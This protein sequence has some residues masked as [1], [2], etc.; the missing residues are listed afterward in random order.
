MA[1]AVL[2]M[3]KPK[4]TKCLQSTPSKS[5]TTSPAS[6]PQA[7][8]SDSRGAGSASNSFPLPPS[9]PPAPL[10]AA[11]ALMSLLP[12]SVPFSSLLRNWTHSSTLELTSPS[13]SARSIVLRMTYVRL[14]LS[15]S[16]LLRPVAQSRRSVSTSRSLTSLTGSRTLSGPS[17]HSSG[18]RPDRSSTSSSSGPARG[19]RMCFVRS[20]S[21]SSHHAESL[22][23]AQFL[24][25]PATPLRRTGLGCRSDGRSNCSTE[26]DGAPFFEVPEEAER[27]R[28]NR[29]PCSTW[30]AFI[31]TEAKCWKGSSDRPPMSSGLPFQLSS[32]SR[33]NNGRRNRPSRSVIAGFASLRTL[34]LASSPPS[35]FASLEYTASSGILL[36]Q[37]TTAPRSVRVRFASRARHRFVLLLHFSAASSPLDLGGGLH[38][39]ISVNRDAAPHSVIS[40]THRRA[41]GPSPELRLRRAASASRPVWPG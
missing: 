39:A 16:L 30:V 23:K 29:R 9:A 38:R 20:T 14:A 18:S 37:N 19:Y 33:I 4:R 25:V 27:R 12:S 26:D 5:C 40:S 11:S 21:F 8:S 6:P 41:D 3:L 36:P 17:S 34:A 10:Y 32:V 31:S 28:T 35:S 13:S 22:S 15:T 7:P 24:S 2:E 1:S